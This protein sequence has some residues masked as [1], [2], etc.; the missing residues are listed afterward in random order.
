MEYIYDNNF[1][2][3]PQKKADANRI[4]SPTLA[5]DERPPCPRSPHVSPM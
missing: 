1:Y 5:A 4:H 3:T 2:E